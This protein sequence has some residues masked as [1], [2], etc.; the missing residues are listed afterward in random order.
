[1]LWLVAGADKREA[2][3]AL[4]DGDESI[5]AGRVTASSSVVVCDAAAR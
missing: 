4:L 5:P 3:A 1:V 2:L